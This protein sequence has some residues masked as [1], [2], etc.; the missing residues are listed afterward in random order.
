MYEP[1]M[2]VHGKAQWTSSI[3]FDS[4]RPWTGARLEFEINLSFTFH[5]NDIPSS[6]QEGR[7]LGQ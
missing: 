7:N 1:F 2:K 5:V 3:E 4:R 6:V